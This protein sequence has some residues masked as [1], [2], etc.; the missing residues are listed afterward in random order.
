MVGFTCSEILKKIIINKPYFH[1]LVNYL[2]QNLVRKMLFSY[3]S[4]MF[5]TVLNTGVNFCFTYL[6]S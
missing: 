3:I 6:E 1:Y 5:G 2:V 4:S